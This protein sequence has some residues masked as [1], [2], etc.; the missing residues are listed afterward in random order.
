MKIE[1]NI[2]KIG[3][4]NGTCAWLAQTI[5]DAKIE[6]GITKAGNHPALWLKRGDKS[7]L[8]AILAQ[9][10][11][12]YGCGETESIPGHAWF[13]SEHGCPDDSVFGVGLTEAAT[14]RWH[15]FQGQVA[16][17]YGREISRLDAECEF[18]VKVEAS[19]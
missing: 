6:A 7:S 4:T 3:Q 1:I 2:P 8:L 12:S 15:E 18:T 14:R 19:K 5:A 16:E 17:V 13:A 10:P 11:N 9:H